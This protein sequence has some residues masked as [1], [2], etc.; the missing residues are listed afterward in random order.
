LFA[1]DVTL[2]PRPTIGEPRRVFSTTGFGMNSYYAG[3]ALEPG[4]RSFLMYRAITSDAR[5]QLVLVLSWLE[6]LRAK[7]GR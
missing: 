6:E 7:A 3:Y 1:A 4:G 2:E 5:S